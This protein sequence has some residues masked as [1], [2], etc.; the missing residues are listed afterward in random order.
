[1]R[2]SGV[3]DSGTNTGPGWAFVAFALVVMGVLQLFDFEVLRY[4]Q[5]WLSRGEYWR[6]FSAHWVHV[7]WPHLMLNAFGLLLCMGITSPRWAIRR[8][9][10]YHLFLTLGISVLFTLLN[11]ELEWYAGYSGVLYGIFV[12]AALDLYQRDKLIALALAIGLSTKIILEQVGGFNI[13]SSKFIGTLVV[14]DAHLYGA[15]L[16]LSIALGERIYTILGNSDSD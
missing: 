9:I 1:M 3:T 12:L 13:S 16:A 15:L 11:P 5:S 14:V 8:W 4:Q 7:N 6:I 10:F 2:R